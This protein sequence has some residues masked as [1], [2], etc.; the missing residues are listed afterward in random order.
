[1]KQ[2]FKG[3]GQGVL[4]ICFE[5]TLKKGL[6]VAMCFLNGALLVCRAL[7]SFDNIFHVYLMNGLQ[8]YIYKKFKV[9]F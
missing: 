2:F 1:M 8:I 9:A 5:L 6:C 7:H 4:S 3:Q